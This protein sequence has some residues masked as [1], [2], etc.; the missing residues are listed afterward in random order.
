[1]CARAGPLPTNQSS[2]DV[3]TIR[4]MFGGWFGVEKMQLAH[5]FCGLPAIRRKICIQNVLPRIRRLDIFFVS[6]T[7]KTLNSSKK[8]LE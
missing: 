7:Y 6:A 4:F 2:K 3:R 8:I 5:N 1:M